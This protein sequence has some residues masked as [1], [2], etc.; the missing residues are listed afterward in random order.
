MRPRSA[1]RHVERAQGQHSIVEIVD[2][3][4]ADRDVL[5]RAESQFRQYALTPSWPW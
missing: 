2:A 4:D 5:P 1:S 3:L